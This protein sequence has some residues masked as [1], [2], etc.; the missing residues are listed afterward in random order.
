[1]SNHADLLTELFFVYFAPLI[2][3]LCQIIGIHAALLLLNRTRTKG[4]LILLIA[5]AAGILTNISL[6]IYELLSARIIIEPIAEIRFWFA[7][8][9]AEILIVGAQFLAI[10][11]ITHEFRSR[12]DL[13]EQ[14]FTSPIPA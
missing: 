5:S 1:M 2:F 6:P 7:A 9:C 3:V 10:A 13:G 11:A 4:P 14:G 8:V 12:L